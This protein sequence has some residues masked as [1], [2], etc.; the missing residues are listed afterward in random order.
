MNDYKPGG[1]SDLFVSESAPD[2]GTLFLKVAFIGGLV[3][4][5]P[6]GVIIALLG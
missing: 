1:L 3:I 5:A 2:F 4:G 6:I